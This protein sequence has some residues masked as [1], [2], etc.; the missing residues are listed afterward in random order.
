MKFLRQPSAWLPVLMSMTVLTII[1][2]HISM[3]GAPIREVDEGTGVHLFQIWIVLE[4]LTMAF[5]AIKW[6]PQA[7]KQALLVLALQIFATFLPIYM[8]FSLKL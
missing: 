4:L 8:V 7:P 5:F 2:I 1:L 3:F 6:L